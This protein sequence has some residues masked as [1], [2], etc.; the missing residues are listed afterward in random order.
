MFDYLKETFMQNA[1]L[2]G[3]ALSISA[4]FLSPY[5]VLNNKALIADGMSHISFTG[6]IIGLL[7]SD[8]PLY[9]AIPFAILTSILITFLTQS[10]TMQGDV[11]IGVVSVFSLALGFII[12]NASTGFNRSI[13]QMLVGNIL[14]VTTSEVIISIILMFII[15]AF[16]LLLYRPLLSLTYD[17]DYARFTGVK[18]SILNYLLSSLTALF[19]VI[20]VRTIGILLISAYIIFPALI[21]SQ[22]AKSFKNTLLIGVGLS[23]ITIIF[24]LLLSYHLDW[25]SSSTI[26]V[27]Y[28]LFFV[29]AFIIG[30]I[31]R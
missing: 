8:Q 30:K 25:P 28:T 5:L 20:G 3:V 10:K 29:V 7:F 11:A 14:T 23:V 27:V 4:A 9:F 22:I 31:R 19:I 24:G 12:I 13:E 1:L 2:L 17:L 15:M 6:I 21:S 16:V 18:T 26:V